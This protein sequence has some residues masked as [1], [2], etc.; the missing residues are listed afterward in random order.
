MMVDWVS[1]TILRLPFMI[2]MD[3]MV[4]LHLVALFVPFMVHSV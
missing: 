1:M 2:F 3:F 4:G